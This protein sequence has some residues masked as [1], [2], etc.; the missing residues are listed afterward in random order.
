MTDFWISCGHNLLDRAPGGGLVVTDAFLKAYFARPELMPEPDADAIEQNLYKALLATPRLPVSA[1]DIA[2]IPDPDARENWQL[3]IDFRDRLL[4]HRTIEGAYAA[5]VRDGAGRM[6]PLFLNQ[7]VHVILRNALDG[8]TDAFIL[9]AAEML[10]RVQT[11]SPHDGALIAAD[12]ETIFGIDGQPLSPLVSMLG[13]PAKVGIDVLKAENTADYW[14]R[15]DQFDMALDLTAG[16][17]GLGAL[18]E[19]MSVFIFHMLGIEVDVEALSEVRDVDLAWYIGLDGEG[20]R[21]GDA[22]WNGEDLDEAMCAQVVGIY[23][24]TFRNP[25]DMNEEIRGEPV[26]LILA[27]AEDKTLRI[28]PQNLIAEL[29]ARQKE[30]VS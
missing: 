17:R 1:Q 15:S 5:M 21:I 6:P 2:A 9:R 24:M 18:G 11:L 25:D 26:Y 7:L 23:R 8:C 20:A 30:T 19:V 29:P 16:R 22:L 28:Q 4:R 14:R 13:Q 10:F 12:D 3:M 27:M